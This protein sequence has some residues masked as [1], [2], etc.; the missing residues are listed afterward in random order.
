MLCS[1]LFLYHYIRLYDLCFAMN[2]NSTV[3]FSYFIKLAECTNCCYLSCD[4]DITHMF[5]L[6]TLVWDKY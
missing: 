2:C 1:I 4:I 6:R 5:V 3:S